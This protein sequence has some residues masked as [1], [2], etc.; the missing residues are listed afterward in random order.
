M[1]ATAE[2]LKAAQLV[3]KEMRALRRIISTRSTEVFGTNLAQ[4]Q[5]KRAH[6][7]F[8]DKGLLNLRRP[9]G[10]L[11]PVVPAR[12]VRTLVTQMHESRSH[13]CVGKT[14]RLINRRFFHPNFTWVIRKGVRGCATCHERKTKNRL[15][16]KRSVDKRRPKPQA[17]GDRQQGRNLGGTPCELVGLST[18]VEAQHSQPEPF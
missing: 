13:A 8:D 2:D 18:V 14:I 5:S 1:N 15:T 10:R 6:L 9:G 11:V 7:S 16:E 4:F 12:S 3:D 17:T